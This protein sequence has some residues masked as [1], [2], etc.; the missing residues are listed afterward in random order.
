M[1]HNG[2]KK[3]MKLHQQNQQHKKKFFFIQHQKITIQK[4]QNLKNMKMRIIPYF[5]YILTRRE[6]KIK[7]FC[8]KN[9]IKF[10][11]ATS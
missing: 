3:K 8:N 2:S 1:E 4:I 7:M 10:E 9:K 5:F 11:N 6:E